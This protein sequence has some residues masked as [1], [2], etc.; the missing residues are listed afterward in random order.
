[1]SEFEFNNEHLSIISELDLDVELRKLETAI[2]ENL[3]L[4]LSND[5]SLSLLK[6]T[7]ALYRSGF[8]VLEDAQYDAI[9]RHFAETNPDH[10][11]VTSV[12]PEATNLGKTVSLPQK[13]LSTDKAYSKKEIEKWLERILKSAQSLHI[14]SSEIDIR[15]TPKLDGYAAF[16]DGNRLYTR[17]D[18][19]KGQDVTRAFERGLKVASHGERGLGA[20]EIVIDKNYFDEELSPYFE[21][22]RNIQA[23]IIAE[24]NVDE[25]VLK[26]INDGACVF[27]PFALIDNWTGHYTELMANFDDIID[28][29]W[30]AVAFDVDGVILEATDPRIKED[31]GATRKFHRWQ[32]AFKINDEAAEVEVIKVTPQTSRKG[33]ITPVAELV[34]TKISGATISRV[35]V[36]HYNMVKSNGVGPGT[37]VQIVRS[38]LVIPK[39]EKVIKKVEPQIPEVCPSCQSHLLWEAD[40]LICPN[41]S[42]CPAQTENTLIHFFKTLG[43]ND[44]FGPKVIEKLSNYSIKHIHEIYAI[45]AHQFA[46]YGFG[47]KTSKNLF[48][49]LQTSREVAVEDWRFLSAFGVSRLGGGNCERL[50][51]HVSLTDLFELSVEDI[52]Q[53][54]G[55]AQLSAEAI[56]EGLAN[57]K[58]EFFKVYSLGFNLSITP[59]ESE[60]ED[61]LS[62]IEGAV[63]VFTGTM[64]QGKRGDMEKQAKS[65]GAKVGKSVT[66]KTTYLVAGEKVGETKINGARDKGVEVI[67]E[68]QYL[69]LIS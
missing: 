50:L 47:E 38:G 30:N 7:N 60:R 19:V 25:R 44:G 17:G 64:L 69:D 49:Q 39:I 4:E 55:F 10:S 66:S 20:G 35:T 14:D 24:K 48:D 65:L 45:K 32:I 23:A 33:R 9:S 58:D 27:Y 53:L 67:S 68:Q 51:E 52:A 13:M 46:G 28:K 63:I 62:P 54:D 16:D 1:M 8:P 6:I 43:N 61:S 26:A 31:M 37:I 15:V 40:N 56:V 21:N 29:I 41:K 12:E 59:K 34:P 2:K 11:F 36:H 57:I 5:E 42:D 18:G 3:F 22:S